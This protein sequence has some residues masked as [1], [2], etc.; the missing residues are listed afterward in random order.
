MPLGE[1]AALATAFCWAATSVAFAEASRRAGA[2]RVNLLR[3]PMALVLLSLAL[4]LSRSPLAAL[5]AS[6]F[7]FLAASAVIGLVVGDLALFAALHRIGPRLASLVMSSA[8]MFAT[9]AGALFLGEEP[10]ARAL[11]GM[12]LTLGGVVWV[13]AERPGQPLEGVKRRAGVLLAFAAAACQGVGLA[14]AKLGMAGGVPPL[15]ATWLRIGIA[16]AVI[17]LLTLLTGKLVGLG[18]RGALRH[19]FVYLALGAFFGPFAGVWLS[20]VAAHHTSVGVAATIMA[21]TP[22]LVIPLVM[23]TERYHPSIRAVAGTLVALAGVALLF[24]R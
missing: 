4:L 11:G 19:A 22:L 20:L 1:T 9:L 3:L 13:V 21:T 23:A 6:S 12:V 16:T 14:L 10:G 17:W 5:T 2:L 24:S 15:A 8:P 7:G 18:L